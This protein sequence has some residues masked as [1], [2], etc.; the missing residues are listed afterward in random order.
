MGHP[1]ECKQFQKL[2]S[3]KVNKPNPTTHN[4]APPR[5]KPSLPPG[6]I[7]TTP[8]GVTRVK[9]ELCPVTETCTAATMP[10]ASPASS[11]SSGRHGG[12]HSKS[13]AAAANSAH[14]AAAAEQARLM[15][16]AAAAASNS[17]FPG[18][19]SPLHPHHHMVR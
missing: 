4:S 13:K 6:H 8:S 12:S 2:T 14:N 9:S 15:A 11:S 18:S 3:I 16:M 19:A 1:V 10:A 7:L 17:P 5:T